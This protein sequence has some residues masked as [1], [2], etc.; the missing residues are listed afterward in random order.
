MRVQPALQGEIF[1][2]LLFKKPF[3]RAVS[4]LLLR[5]FSEFKKN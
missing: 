1:M 3:N 4:A 2:N 5:G